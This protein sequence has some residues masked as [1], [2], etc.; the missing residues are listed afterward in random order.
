MFDG[1]HNRQFIEKIYIANDKSLEITLE[2]FLTD[3]I[4]KEEGELHVIIQEDANKTKKEIAQ[5]EIQQHKKK[6]DMKQYLLA[7]YGGI[8]G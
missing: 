7:E 3:N 5:G 8:L 2:L 4:P 1:K 6:Q